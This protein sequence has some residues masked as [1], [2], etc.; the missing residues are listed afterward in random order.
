MAITV[1]P[2]K[3]ATISGGHSG[4]GGPTPWWNTV[5]VLSETPPG[6]LP[7]VAYN[8]PIGSTF[9]GLTNWLFGSAFGFA[10]PAAGKKVVKVRG[11]V[12]A[13][14]TAG[15]VVISRA[16]LRIRLP[17]RGYYENMAASEKA[18][19]LALTTDWADYTIEWEGGVVFPANPARVGELVATP[20]FGFGITATGSNNAKVEVDVSSMQLELDDG[21]AGEETGRPTLLNAL[22]AV[23][24]ELVKVRELLELTVPT[25]ERADTAIGKADALLTEMGEDTP[26]A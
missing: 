7:S 4:S 18:P 21:A 8:G 1:T 17:E 23:K 16:S 6:G 24:D 11:R 12:R 15:D 20:E 10:R 13:R 9:N 14:K 3:L 22:T 25:I 19:N 26:P 5:G 2:F